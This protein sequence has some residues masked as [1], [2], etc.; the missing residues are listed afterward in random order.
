MQQNI[1]NTHFENCCISKQGMNHESSSV[2]LIKSCILI[3]LLSECHFNRSAKYI[4]LDINEHI[5][6]IFQS[7]YNNYIINKYQTKV[8]FTS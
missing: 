7:H 2:T 3:P 6:T 4:Y 8:F 1:L 5:L